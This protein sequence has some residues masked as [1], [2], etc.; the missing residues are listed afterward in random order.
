MKNIFNELS[1]PFD[2]ADVSWRVGSTTKDKTRG[3]AL[4]YI[5]SRDVQDRLD[6][7]MGADWQD[8]Y[9]AMPDGTYCCSIGL[10]I[11][12]EWRWRS[13]GAGMVAVGSA[14]NPQTQRDADAKEM[15]QKGSY[16]DS[17]KRAAVKWG[18]ARYL[19]D[20]SSPWVEI[21]NNRIKESELPKLNAL[22]QD[23]MADVKLVATAVEKSN[24]GIEI[25]KAF[26]TS[27]TE[28]QR[29]V[30]S[31]HHEKLKSNAQSVS[32]NPKQQKAA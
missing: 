31:P 7:V 24:A 2:P 14:V 6:F 4:A 20:M 5:D 18:V 10:K 13:D 16:S 27:I 30:L 21:E 25:Y 8:R 3:M 29:K 32:N 26:F 22:L 17:F 23:Q 15:A 9:E 12:G 11:D 19:Y 1:A 28:A